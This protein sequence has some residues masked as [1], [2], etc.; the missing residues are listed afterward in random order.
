M[1]STTM[2]SISTDEKTGLRT[3]ICASHCI[4]TSLHGL[5]VLKRLG[6]LD[7][8]PVEG[9]EPAY[10]RHHATPARPRL[11]DA[12]LDAPVDHRED[13]RRP[14]LHDDAVRRH[15]GHRRVARGELD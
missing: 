3:Q 8:H 5:A 12:L 13:P 1:P 15:D 7:D 10:D 14:L 2:R 4:S 11:H 6:R 9:L